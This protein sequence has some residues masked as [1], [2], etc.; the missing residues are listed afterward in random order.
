MS[1]KNYMSVFDEVA[2]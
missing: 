1:Y 2:E